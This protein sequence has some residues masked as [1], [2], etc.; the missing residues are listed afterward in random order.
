MQQR[1]LVGRCQGCLLVDGPWQPQHFGN[2][3]AF[4]KTVANHNSSI[5]SEKRLCRC[6]KERN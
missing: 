6:I 4:K 5:G 1:L 3:E 2:A